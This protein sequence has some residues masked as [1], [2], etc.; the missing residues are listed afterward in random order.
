MSAIIP[1]THPAANRSRTI[2][3]SARD[4]RQSMKHLMLVALVS[5]TTAAHAATMARVAGVVDSRTVI[6]ETNGIGKEAKLAR[7]TVSPNDETLARDYLRRTIGSAWVL[8]EPAP[9]GVFLY[10]SPDSLFVNGEMARGAYL[11]PG[12]PMIWLGE[13]SAERAPEVRRR[14]AGAPPK[15]AKP[16]RPPRRR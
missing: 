5:F 10:R 7:V 8:V 16:R 3:F 1:R 14:A 15:P 13:V 11:Q 4:I 2:G 9:D 6:L 12:T